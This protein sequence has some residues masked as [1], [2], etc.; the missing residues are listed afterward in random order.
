MS[1]NQTKRRITC[2]GP[3]CTA[4]A[5]VPVALSDG[6]ADSRLLPGTPSPLA[7]W[8]F[9]VG[10]YEDRH[11]CPCCGS[12]MLPPHEQWAETRGT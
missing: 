4:E 6:L 2:D 11:Y 7:G 9:V 5:P 12:K 10:T 3:D 1:L 8:V